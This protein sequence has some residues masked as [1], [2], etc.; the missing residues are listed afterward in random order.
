M[1]R[2]NDPTLTCDLERILDVSDVQAA[3]AVHLA[4]GLSYIDAASEVGVSTETVLTWIEFSF[5]FQARY[6]L[7]VHLHA[8]QA[9]NLD[10]AAA[11]LDRERLLDELDTAGD[12]ALAAASPSKVRV[13]TPARRRS[14]PLTAADLFDLKVEHE[15]L[16]ADRAAMDLTFLESELNEQSSPSRQ[17]LLR[18]IAHTHS[19][20]LAATEGDPQQ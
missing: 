14:M 12:G 5:G 15:F 20:A 3:A 18:E 11:T 4:D 17:R 16:L 13:P 2:N 19:A 10:R 7:L 8:E 6:E 9:T 1:T